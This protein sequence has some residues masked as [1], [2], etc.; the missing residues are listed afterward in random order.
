MNW[1][2]P[3]VPT[4]YHMKVDHFMFVIHV[5]SDPKEFDTWYRIAGTVP[6]V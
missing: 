4:W 6:E 2:R 3:K 1:T 5:S